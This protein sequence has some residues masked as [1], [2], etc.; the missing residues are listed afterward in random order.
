VE[1]AVSVYDGGFAERPEDEV[2][3]EREWWMEYEEVSAR[4]WAKVQKSEGCWEW[5]GC[6]LDRGYGAF[7]LRNAWRGVRKGT[8]RTHRISWALHYGDV[9]AGMLVCH[10]CDNPSCV[11]PDHLFLGTDADN[12]RDRAAKGRTVSAQ[13]DKTRCP[14]GHAYDGDNLYLSPKGD[15]RCRECARA[16][17]RARGWYVRGRGRRRAA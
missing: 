1:A 8:C 5:N 15:R 2:E 9:P 10:H 6:K 12:N 16:R 3:Q 11:R 13:S 14:S 17:D 4:F 7:H